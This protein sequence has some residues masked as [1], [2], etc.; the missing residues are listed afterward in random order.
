MVP[1]HR[2]PVAAFIHMHY[3]L[4]ISQLLQGR[5][6]HVRRDLWTR[7]ALIAILNITIHFAVVLIT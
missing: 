3:F 4:V 5:L 7:T 1:L 6:G 2:L